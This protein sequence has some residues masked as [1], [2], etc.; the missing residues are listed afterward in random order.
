[1]GFSSGECKHVKGI[2]LDLKISDNLSREM[3]INKK[4]SGV[5]IFNQNQIYIH[6]PYAF[7]SGHPIIF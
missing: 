6:N 7:A 1:M 2:N 3:D 5:K 4:L